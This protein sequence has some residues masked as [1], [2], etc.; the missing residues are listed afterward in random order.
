MQINKTIRTWGS[1][2][3]KN[4]P[5]EK[6]NLHASPNLDT[7]ILKWLSAPFFDN[8]FIVTKP[9]AVIGKTSIWCA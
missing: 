1:A 4:S 3:N 9:E 7:A 8:T 2:S 5:L 6:S